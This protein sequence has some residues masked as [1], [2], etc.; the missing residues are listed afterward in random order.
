MTSKII[1]MAEKLQ[2]AED[3]LLASLLRPT[4][5]EDDG[6]SSRIVARIRRGIWIRR[7]AMP[8]VLLLGGAIAGKSVLQLGAV[9]AA[10]GGA[11][12]IDPPALPATL[13]A[14]MP[15]MITVGCLMLIGIVMFE[16]SEE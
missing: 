7:L 13:L 2:D 15:A 11:L 10:L 1:N 14:Q 12:P 9:L 5:I 4:P 8:A 3:R 16:L 6:F